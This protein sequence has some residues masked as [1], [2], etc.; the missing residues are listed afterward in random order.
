MSL[1][2]PISVSRSAR[3][4]ASMSGDTVFVRQVSTHEVD[5]HTELLGDWSLSYD[6]LDR[7]AFEGGFVDIRWPGMQL[8]VETTNRRLRQR[9]GFSPDTLA[10]GTLVAGDGE[11][12]C[13]GR[14]S[15]RDSLMV[16]H[17]AEIDFCSPTN[18]AVAGFVVDHYGLLE[19]T[20]SVPALP[21]AFKSAVTVIAN[22]PESA[23]VPLRALLQS[24]TETAL[25]HPKALQD[26]N[27]QQG[28]RDDLL[29]ALEGATGAAVPDDAACADT[30]RKVVDRACEIMLSQQDSPPTLLEVCQRLG[31]SPRKLGYCFQDILGLSPAR[32]IK[33]VRLNAVRR[34]LRRA[35]ASHT[36]VYDVAARWGFWHFGHFSADYKRQ[37]AEL[38]SQTLRGAMLA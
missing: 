27:V 34:D 13:N 8:F 2:S 3:A 23:R 1:A 16:V 29:L 9:G 14:R 33:T 24:V 21:D 35:A 37:F 10:L 31:T 32:Y 12:L 36:S 30:R 20:A 7:G 38:P 22:P 26:P 25:R 15:G 6:Q 18:C 11:M 5:E 19:A 17:G 28:I 4:P